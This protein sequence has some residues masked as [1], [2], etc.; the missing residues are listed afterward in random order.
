LSEKFEKIKI[1][2]K[3]F[4]EIYQI[5]DEDS[6][7]DIPEEKKEEVKKSQLDHDIEEADKKLEEDFIPEDAEV[8]EYEFT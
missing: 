6:T 3:E 7:H 1:S 5:D 4:D 2:Q 8:F